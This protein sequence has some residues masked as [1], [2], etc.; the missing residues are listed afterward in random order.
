MSLDGYVEKEMKYVDRKNM[1][2]DFIIWTPVDVIGGFRGA[3]KGI[4][5]IND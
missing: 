5:A 4:A 1:E 3:I 2:D